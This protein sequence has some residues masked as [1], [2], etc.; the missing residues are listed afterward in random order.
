MMSTNDYLNFLDYGKFTMSY[1]LINKDIG[2]FISY[3][4]SYD[5]YNWNHV[6]Y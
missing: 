6:F 2:K 4:N 3:I 5:K 1:N